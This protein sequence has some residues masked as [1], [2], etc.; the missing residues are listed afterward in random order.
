MFLLSSGTG[1]PPEKLKAAALCSDKAAAGKRGFPYRADGAG[2]A[3]SERRA[4]PIRGAP[5][6]DCC[7]LQCR[8]KAL[9]A[10]KTRAAAAGQAAGVTGE[11]GADAA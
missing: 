7:P 4:A 8:W 6:G 10:R 1:F 5:D 2:R 11:V 3:A 9:H